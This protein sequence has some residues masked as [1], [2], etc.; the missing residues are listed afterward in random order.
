MDQIYEQILKHLEQAVNSLA[1][2]VPEP[3][4]T[5]FGDFRAFRYT[6]KTILQ[7]IVL[8]LAR[9]VS[10]LDAARLLLNH[11][12]V[13]E[14]ACL[15]RVLDEIQEDIFF[16]VFGFLQGDYTSSLHRDYIV[17]TWMHFLKKNSMLI[18]RFNQPRS[19]PWSLDGKFE[20]IWPVLHLIHSTQAVEQ[21]CCEL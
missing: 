10:T 21:N 6:E 3:K 9:M 17:I 7:A 11:G 12:F 15:Q 19:G 13:Q 4:L 5:E 20:H 16:L 18:R 1:D 8:K 14:Q 2:Q